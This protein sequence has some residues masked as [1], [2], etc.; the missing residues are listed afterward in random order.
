MLEDFVKVPPSHMKVPPDHYKGLQATSKGHASW[1]ILVAV[2]GKCKQANEFQLH[3][4]GIWPHQL[5]MSRIGPIRDSR[6]SYLNP[7]IGVECRLFI[8]S[9]SLQVIDQSLNMLYR[10]PLSAYMQLCESCGCLGILNAINILLLHYRHY[11][12]QEY[13]KCIMYCICLLKQICA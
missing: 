10:I 2:M 6:L 9:K 11:T 4:Y 13:E 1:L 12:L 5:F 8:P 3:H 7:S